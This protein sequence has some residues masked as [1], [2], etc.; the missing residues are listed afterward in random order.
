MKV[1]FS[2]I[3]ITTFLL[4]NST[5]RGRPIPSL[6]TTEEHAHDSHIERR[7]DGAQDS[8]L[9]DDSDNHDGTHSQSVNHIS[10]SPHTQN[11][12][13]PSLPL[14]PPP[15]VP[16][17]LLPYGQHP[18]PHLVQTTQL[19]QNWNEYSQTTSS[20]VH[21]AHNVLAMGHHQP[22]YTHPDQSSYQASSAQAHPYHPIDEYL[23]TPWSQ[24]SE[25][26]PNEYLQ[27]H[28][29]SSIPF[30]PQAQIPGSSFPLSQHTSRPEPQSMATSNK[31]TP[32]SHPL[33]Q[34]H[35]Q[36]SPALPKVQSLESDPPKGT[37]TSDVKS[38]PMV[39][40]NGKRPGENQ[41]EA[42]SLSEQLSRRRDAYRY[43]LESK[44][45]TELHDPR[46]RHELEAKIE[47]WR[48][49]SR[50]MS[51]HCQ[52]ELKGMLVTWR[53]IGLENWEIH[54]LT[55][56]FERKFMMLEPKPDDRDE[57]S[58]TTSSLIH[59]PHNVLG[60]QPPMHTHLDTSSSQAR[61]SAPA[62]PYDP[63]PNIAGHLPNTY[64]DPTSQIPSNQGAPFSQPLQDHVQSSPAL[65]N[66]QSLESDP[67]KGTVTS[68]VDLGSKV[69]RRRNK[70]YPIGKP[71]AEAR[72]DYHRNKLNS[73]Y[74]DLNDRKKRE[75]V[76]TAIKIWRAESP[77][78]F[79]ICQDELKEK[80]H[81][82]E[83]LKLEKSAMDV[84]KLGFERDFMKK[85][86]RDPVPPLGEKE[87]RQEVEKLLE[88]NKD[89]RDEHFRAEVQAEVDRW[90]EKLRE[91]NPEELR[92]VQNKV[93]SRRF[94]LRALR[95]DTLERA[96]SQLV[97]ERQLM[98]ENRTADGTV[99]TQGHAAREKLEANKNLR[100]HTG[101]G[102]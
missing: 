33:Q 80:L 12:V 36:S 85:H 41:K 39:N 69:V 78:M 15:H 24:I 5:V 8:F 21:P 30:T 51:L 66:L 27:S 67:P 65:P 97:F 31:P 99:N 77:Y 82:W 32:F 55:L 19:P 53:R 68:N 91:E 1:H 90:K 7:S 22:T 4:L 20:L 49:K 3:V 18:G 16:S 73:K 45:Y 14:G 35:V 83:S 28:P 72:Q 84:A 13:V 86:P 94:V 40:A 2:A 61:S 64:L 63:N 46:T 29:T 100:D 81:H 75:D 76:E 42:I 70:G 58:H 54:L 48:G 6:S 38:G 74:G 101:A 59:P 37:V 71:I 17:E 60:K 57:Y 92:R 95:L 88:D 43:I 50:Y 11:W 25:P 44:E 56:G 10:P 47:D 89:M 34:D 93:A 23:A 96:I 98:W 9:S 102:L 62:H 52:N 87:K 26:I 79:S